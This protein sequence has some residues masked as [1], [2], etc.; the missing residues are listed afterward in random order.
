MEYLSFARAG[1]LPLGTIHPD[2]RSHGFWSASGLCIIISQRKSSYKLDR[3]IQ[4]LPDLL[5]RKGANRKM[6]LSW[7]VDADAS[8]Y[9][10]N[11]WRAVPEVHNSWAQRERQLKHTSLRIVH[12]EVSRGLGGTANP[13][14]DRRER[15][16]QPWAFGR[17]LSRIVVRNLCMHK[18]KAKNQFGAPGKSRTRQIACVDNVEPMKC[19]CTIRNVSRSLNLAGFR[20]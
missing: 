19:K 13:D 12:N 8:R 14:F 9:P 2:F 16:D 20:E 17:D 10:G 4:W 15:H 7:V 3:S 11:F 18:K 6:F 5:W 1:V